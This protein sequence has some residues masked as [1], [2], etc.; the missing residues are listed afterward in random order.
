M[1]ELARF[2]VFGNPIAHS[3][4]P[5][6][7]RLFADQ[8]GLKLSYEKIAVPE[9]DFEKAVADFFQSGGR[10]LNITLPFKMRAARLCDELLPAAALS[11]A[12]N[13][14]WYRNGILVGDSTDGAG[15][16]QDFEQLAW[17]LRQRRLLL[18]GAGGAARGVLPSLLAQDP[19][20]I[21]IAN[22]S[23]QRAVDLAEQAGDPRVLGLS[24]DALAEQGVFDLIINATSASVSGALPTLPN[25]IVGKDSACYDMMYAAKPTVFMEWAMAR[26]VQACA[27]GLGMLVGQA[28]A[29]FHHW[30]GQRVQIGP[31][32]ENLRRQMG[33]EA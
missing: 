10:G 1:P 22:R 30:H 16:L 32:V 25:G 28:A 12:A 9:D 27:D 14:L 2:A 31:V 4:S 17:T 23:S 26:G 21:V 24:L 33:Q 20:Q 13:T 18:I 15:L 8:L 29:S 7:H 3:R 5:D 11:E 6:I 19:K